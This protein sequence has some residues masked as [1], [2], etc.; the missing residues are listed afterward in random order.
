MIEMVSSYLQWFGA[1]TIATLWLPL[2]LWTAAALPIYGLVQWREIGTPHVRYYIL[3]ALLLALPVGLVLGGV[4]DMGTLFETTASGAAEVSNEFTAIISLPEVSSTTQAPAAG[5]WN[6]YHGLGLLTV[7]AALLAGWRLLMLA[8]EACKLYMLRCRLGG[9]FD[10]GVHRTCL[11]LRRQMRLRRHVDV[12]VTSDET[13]PM[14]F[15]LF[16]PTIVVPESIASRPEQLRMTLAHELTHVRRWDYLRGL[17]E[18]LIGSLFVIQPLTRQLRRQISSCREMACDMEV[19]DLLSCSKRA[20]AALLFETSLPTPRR[21]PFAVAMSDSPGH[22]KRRILAMKTHA[23]KSLRSARTA[24]LAAG[25]AVLCIAGL[26]SGCATGS[27]DTYLNVKVGAWE[28]IVRSG[29]DQPLT[30]SPAEPPANAVTAERSSEEEIDDRADD[31]GPDVFVAVEQMPKL[32]GGLSALAQKIEYPEEARQAG[33]EGNVIIQF[34][35]DEQGNVIE[36]SVL[37]GIGAGCDREAL[38]VVRQAEFEPGRQRGKPVQVKMSL[39]VRFTLDN[40]N[41]EVSNAENPSATTLHIRSDETVLV[42]HDQVLL[43]HLSD[44]LNRLPAAREGLHVYVDDGTPMGFVSEV[45]KRIR[46]T[47]IQRITYRTG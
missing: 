27:T 41:E 30:S 8:G 47:Q 21:E 35:V 31:D 33:V 7:L 14:T 23:G 17:V 28:L 18:R 16:H 45:Q 38:E 22:L 43:A 44:H 2:L 25:V 32:K 34:V 1:G 40:E 11:R 36:P 9:W 15:G 26:M 24:G 19:L 20:Y 46:R 29:A 4:L 13:V 42:N 12:L 37:R 39:P 10:R 6:V 3:Q 5:A